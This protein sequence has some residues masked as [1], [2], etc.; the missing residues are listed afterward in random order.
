MYIVNEFRGKYYFLSNF[1]NAPVEY[2]GLT[3]KRPR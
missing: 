2:N 3:F 1:Y